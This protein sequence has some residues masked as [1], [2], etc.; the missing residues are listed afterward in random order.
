MTAKCKPQLSKGQKNTFVLPKNN[1]N[2]FKKT[3][4]GCHRAFSFIAIQYQLN[5]SAEPITIS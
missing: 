3:L 2:A 4:D 5:Y 1:I